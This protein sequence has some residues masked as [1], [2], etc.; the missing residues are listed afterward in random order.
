M[1]YEV[2]TGCYE[3]I[4]G[5]NSFNYPYDSERKCLI[6]SGCDECE[7]KGYTELSDDFYDDFEEWHKKQES[8]VV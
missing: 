2:C 4:D 8:S 6:G 7:E 5:H 3:S 1:I